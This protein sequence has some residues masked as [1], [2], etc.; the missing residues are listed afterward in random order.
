[1]CNAKTAENTKSKVNINST[2]L[3]QNK[4]LIT[5]Q[6]K[7]KEMTSALGLALTLSDY[8]NSKIYSIVYTGS[9]RLSLH[10]TNIVYSLR[11][12]I[13]AFL[14]FK[15]YPK[16]SAHLGMGPSNFSCLFL[17]S[18][19]PKCNGYIFIGVYM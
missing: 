10:H 2:P 3:S 11:P 16:I 19:L 5:N 4:K 6:I 13:S 1:M 8:Y 15:I 17:L 14:K 9:W 12:I 7:W 18:L